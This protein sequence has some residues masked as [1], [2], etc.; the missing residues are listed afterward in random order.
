[1]H[2]LE[3]AENFNESMYFNVFDRE[4]EHRRLVPAG[5]SAQRRP[6]GDEL[7][8]LPAGWTD[9]L[10]VSRP[11][12]HDNDALDG[13]GMRFDGGGAA[14][15]PESSYQGKL[16]VLSDPQE[17]P[18]RPSAS[19]TTRWSPRDRSGVR[20]VSPMFGGEAVNRDGSPIKQDAAAVLRPGHTSS[21]PVA[22]RII[23]AMRTSRSM[24]WACGITPGA[25]A[26]GRPCTGIAGC[27]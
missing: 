27:R 8:C 10:H 23:V 26:T 20:G 7:L 19:R 6:R 3:E 9:R 18:I 14:Q 21:T 15:T 16:C 13:G 17:M 11:E 25:R 1:M 22:R 4:R 5:Q 2:P 12:R 24:G